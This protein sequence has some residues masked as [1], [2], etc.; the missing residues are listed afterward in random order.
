MLN[1]FR[2]VLSLMF[3]PSLWIEMMDTYKQS[4]YDDQQI[5]QQVDQLPKRRTMWS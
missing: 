4:K 2:L 5:E 3:E 1:L